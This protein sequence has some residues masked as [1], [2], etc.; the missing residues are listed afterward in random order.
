VIL[1]S[2]SESCAT[3]P[4]AGLIIHVDSARLHIAQKTLGFCRENLLETAP[5]LPHSPN[6]ASSDFFLFGHVK[7]QLEGIEFPS[8]EALLAA[9]QQIL[10]DLTVNTLVAIF[11]N[12]VEGL[13][14]V[15][16]N[17]GHCY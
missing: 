14:W 8:E 2:P 11:A 7:H 13:K 12:W 4:G 16:L 10:S 3:E 17:K 6:L 9:I 1:Q 15:A 5:P